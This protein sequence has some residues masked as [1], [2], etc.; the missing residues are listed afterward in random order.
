MFKNLAK[1][2]PLSRKPT[3]L[4]LN[5]ANVSLQ[6]IAN[7]TLIVNLKTGKMDWK[8]KWLWCIGIAAWWFTAV[9]RVGGKTIVTGQ[10]RDTECHKYK[11]YR[12]GDECTAKVGDRDW[13]WIEP[14]ECGGEYVDIDHWCCMS[15]D[16]NCTTNFTSARQSER[17]PHKYLAPMKCQGKVISSGQTCNGECKP[18]SK[19]ILGQ[20]Y[21][22]AAWQLPG[23]Q[24]ACSANISSPC[25][26][27]YD[28]CHGEP[29]CPDKSDLRWCLG[30]NYHNRTGLTTCTR[31]IRS[32]VVWDNDVFDGQFHCL[33]RSDED[34][35][36]LYDQRINRGAPELRNC[37]N[38]TRP[39]F[40]PQ[41]W[42]WTSSGYLT[43]DYECIP[44][45]YWWRKGRSNLTKST[46]IVNPRICGDFSV[47]SDKP[48]GP[49]NAM[50]CFGHWSGECILKG[51]FGV[52]AGFFFALLGAT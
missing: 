36:L 42:F 45:W 31:H 14:C 23:H 16:N 43:E 30:D 44:A 19:A 34:P 20:T 22:P 4:L 5:L 29:M 15:P 17:N 33:D 10:W 49:D 41:N 11:H 7:L 47:W 48:C 50:R 9:G 46:Q 39:S 37:T 32:Q 6:V 2:S 13:L 26:D 28:L 1:K 12:C 3:V 40:W 35:F 38:S 27:G 8:V 51:E 52:K 18:Q 21:I 25:V 24:R